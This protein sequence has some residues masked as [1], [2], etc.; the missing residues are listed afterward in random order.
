MIAVKGF[1]AFRN[2]FVP[3]SLPLPATGR[4]F[5]DLRVEELCH[6]GSRHVPDEQYRRHHS[7]TRLPK[8]GKLFCKVLITF[9]L[10][11]DEIEG[12]PATAT[13]PGCSLA[14]ADPV[15]LTR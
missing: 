8:T 11:P 2:T 1:S 12:L 6:D 3:A 14:A 4:P 7:H 5:D 9:R 15:A 10:S 13:S